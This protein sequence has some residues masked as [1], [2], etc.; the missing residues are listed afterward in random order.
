MMDSMISSIKNHIL[1]KTY[2]INKGYYVQKSYY[3]RTYLDNFI[4]SMIDRYEN[5]DFV[6]DV[7]DNILFITFILFVVALTIVI[8]RRTGFY[9]VIG[10][11]L[12]YIK[13]AL[14]GDALYYWAVHVLDLITL[15]SPILAILLFISYHIITL[16]EELIL[17]FIF[18]LFVHND[19]GSLL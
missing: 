8:I 10:N 1:Q 6:R 18:L 14:Y 3:Q 7:I 16:N 2:Y 17:A 13:A 11:F 4:L 5:F 15:F 12:D 19:F 9:I